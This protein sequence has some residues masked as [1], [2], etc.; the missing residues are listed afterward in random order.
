MD[1]ETKLLFAEA[2]RSVKKPLVISLFEIEDTLGRDAVRYACTEIAS[3]LIAM[4][5]YSLGIKEINAEF[6]D[7]LASL[8]DMKFKQIEEDEAAVNN[9]VQ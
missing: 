5:V 4:C 1:D 7:G 6:W 8:V 9:Q 2:V 3:T